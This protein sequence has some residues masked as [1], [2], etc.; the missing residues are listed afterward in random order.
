MGVCGAW[1]KWTQ[2]VFWS[3]LATRDTK[4]LLLTEQPSLKVRRERYGGP[5]PE[6]PTAPVE[7][8]IDAGPEPLD[9]VVSQFVRA[10]DHFRAGRRQRV[11]VPTEIRSPRLERVQV[12]AI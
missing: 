6:Y 5:V 7:L 8:F 3:C 2:F 11:Q 9:L 4:S 10:D 12:I 1:N